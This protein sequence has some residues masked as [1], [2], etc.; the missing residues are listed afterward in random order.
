MDHK[1]KIIIY[2]Y[3]VFLISLFNIGYSM[4]KTVKTIQLNFGENKISITKIHVKGNGDKCAVLLHGMGLYSDYYFDAIDYLPSE[5]STIYFIDMLNHGLSSGKKGFLPDQDTIVKVLDFTFDYI[6]KNEKIHNIDL[7][8]G[9]SMGGIFALYYLLQTPDVNIPNIII[10]ST[11]LIVKYFN[12]IDLRNIK[13]IP[14]YLFAREKLIV[15]IKKLNHQ[16]VEDKKLL[17]RI[18][19]DKMVPDLININYLITL[20]GMISEINKNYSKLNK[21]ILFFYG[22]FD[23]ISNA[24]K[25]AEKNSRLSNVRTIVLKDQLHAIF[26][27]KNNEYKNQIDEWLNEL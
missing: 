7:L 18:K 16:L 14:Y 11:P 2:I 1:P 6:L 23:A 22:E 17:D 3:I 4:E 21:N 9:E 10:F 19:N 20:K 27:N 8:I 15:P 24:K 26:W 25:I 13:L 5:F 12:F